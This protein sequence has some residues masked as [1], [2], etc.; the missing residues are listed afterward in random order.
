MLEPRRLLGSQRL[1]FVSFFLVLAGCGGSSTPEPYTDEA[2]NYQVMVVGRTKSSQQKL[3]SPAGELTVFAMESSDGNKTSRSVTYT[4]YPAQIIQSRRPEAMLE[5]LE[6]AMTPGGQWSIES[7]RS[8]VLDGHP[9]REIHFSASAPG[10]PEKGAGAAR[11]Y[12]VGNRL[13]QVIIVGPASKVTAGELGDYVNSFELLR[14]VAVAAHGTGPPPGVTAVT[15][16]VQAKP[17]DSPAPP[18]LSSQPPPPPSAPEPET[19]PKLAV[20]QSEPS[21]PTQAA[22]PGNARAV[23]DG[24]IGQDHHAE[25]DD[26][27]GPASGVPSPAARA[28]SPRAPNTRLAPPT[29]ENRV[30]RNEDSGP[31]PARAADVAVKA[32]AE[33]VFSYRPEPN[34]NE[35]ERFRE[36]PKEGGVLVGVAVG[37]INAFGGAKVGM[38][39]PIF[40]AKSNVVNGR[41]HGRNILPSVRV[42]AR[43]GYAV[44]GINTRTGLL[45]DAFQ[46]VFMKL[47]NGQLDP[48]D[49]YTSNWLGDP[50]G[51]SDGGATGDGNLIVGIHG[52]SN[53]REVNMLGL[54]VAE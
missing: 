14:K 22:I 33:P 27:R 24:V 37:Y 54:V 5:G 17:A 49:S 7:Q 18:A 30:A 12:L 45:L 4:D 46:L 34:G 41:R 11:I 16:A 48:A 20:A 44:G 3:A 43:P 25:R 8:I 29:G 9:G 53:G 15:Q 2:G 39:Q 32:K 13:Y 19:E 35:R 21:E 28:P 52:R 40:R 51:G 10:N 26:N 36:V 47:K 31:D 38:I 42:I 1:A 6:R 23:Q 50:R